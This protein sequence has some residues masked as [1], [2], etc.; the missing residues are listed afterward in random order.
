[1][2]GTDYPLLDL[3]LTILWFFVLVIWITTVI[4]VIVDIFRSRD[5]S[6]WGKAGWFILVLLL[7]IIGVIA[8]LIARGTNM[9]EHRRKDV[10]AQDK[11]MRQYVESVGGGETTKADE[12]EKLANLRDRG[13]LTEEE[14]ATQKAQ[15]LA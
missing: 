4:L 14:F 12:L 1:M 6:G 15:L 3:F 10:E 7:P 2:V 13:V 5:L 11:A 8:Y 9:A